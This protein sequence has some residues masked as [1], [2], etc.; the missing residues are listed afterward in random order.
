MKTLTIED[1][2][3]ILDSLRFSETVLHKN[4]A[5]ELK[6]KEKETLTAERIQRVIAKLT[7]EDLHFHTEGKL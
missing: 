2:N 7:T 6:G 1:A 4:I 5:I 3:T